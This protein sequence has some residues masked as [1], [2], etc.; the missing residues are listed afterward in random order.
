MTSADCV[1]E[2]ID[3]LSRE[4]NALLGLLEF[5]KSH[6]YPSSIASILFKMI[7]ARDRELQGISISQH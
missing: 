5:T 4:I 7:K 2:R 3:R 1:S 6:Q